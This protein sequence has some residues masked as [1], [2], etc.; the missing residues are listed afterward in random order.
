MSVFLYLD[1][2]WITKSASVEYEYWSGPGTPPLTGGWQ[3]T[4]TGAWKR[5]V[6]AGGKAPDSPE[7]ASGGKT[8]SADNK[9]EDASEEDLTEDPK[10]P[11]PSQKPK[12]NLKRIAASGFSA[13]QSLGSAAT[14]LEGGGQ[15]ATATIQYA[16]GGVVSAGHALLSSDDN[17]KQKKETGSTDKKTGSTDKK[18]PSK[19]AAKSA[20]EK[21]VQ[22]STFGSVTPSE[23]RARVKYESSYAKRPTGVASGEQ[24]EPDDPDV[25]KQWKH[26]DEDSVS[27]EVER[28][29]QEQ[30][31]PTEKSFSASLVQAIT[32]SLTNEI[33]QYV[34]TDL[35]ADFMVA[36]LGY[37]PNSVKK[38]LMT[39]QGR[40]RHRFNEWAHE[41]LNKS[42]SD[43]LR[44]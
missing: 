35:E 37:D 7:E 39:I 12:T 27:A 15:L 1:D 17:A 28:M 4:P 16:G 19:S 38:G 29:L 34:P 40:D 44:Y 30:E 13:G 33:R 23:E 26:S 8:E 20:V 2:D 10:K 5:P 32:K 41:R 31:E 11:A 25:G 14:R 18:T 6:G 36:E 21:A 22:P 24:H 9:T 3:Q 43:L 42:L